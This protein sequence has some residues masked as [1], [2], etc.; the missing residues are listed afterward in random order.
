MIDLSTLP[1]P[2]ALPLVDAE[3]IYARKKDALLALAPEL[4][5]VLALEME[6]LTKYLQR[7]AWDEYVLRQG[8]NDRTRAMLLAFATGAD[9]DHLAAL[10]G[11]RRLML[12]AGNLASVPP[13]EPVME[14]DADL[15]RRIQLAPDAMS[16]AGPRGA[17]VAH[18]LAAHPDVKDVSVT[19]PAPGVV[20]LHVLARSG[21]GAPGGAVLAAV[22]AAVNAETVRPLTDQ[23][24]VVPASLV[25]VAI[26]A[27]IVLMEGPSSATV[28]AAVD[29]ALD[30]YLDA[31]R[32]L[33]GDITR[34]GLMAAL[35]QSGVHR[36]T[37]AQPA[38]DV[39]LGVHQAP[40]ITSVTL[41]PGGRD[42]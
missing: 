28:M 41:A 27:T 24:D 30:A 23:V 16:V 26:E 35:H 7:D 4:A 36:V 1:P 5:G 29:A 8:W 38:A 37:L 15:R 22:L 40:K 25:N 11:V 34:S 21:D 10:F 32:R 42:A 39:L 9:L 3:A 2:E 12:V 18:A 13:V 6:P 33:G 20:R 14:A 19:S 31:Q 17:Y